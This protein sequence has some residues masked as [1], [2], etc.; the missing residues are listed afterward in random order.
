MSAQ[1]KRIKS[2]E[3][4]GFNMGLDDDD[5]DIL[6]GQG[7]TV[8][9]EQKDQKESGEVGVRVEESAESES[10]DSGEFDA[11]NSAASKTYQ[12]V[13]RRYRPK[14]FDELVGQSH[15]SQALANAILTNRVGHAYLFTGARGVGKT[16]TA[17]IFS[18]SLNCVLGPTSKP[19]G[20]CDSCVGISTGEDIDVLEIDGASNRGI[21]EIRQLRLN[22]SICPSRSRFK[23][24]II[25]EVH[26]LTRE[27]FNALLKILE[28]PPAH[29]KFIFCTTEPSKIPVTIL[30][31]CQRYDFAGIETL[32]IAKHLLEIAANEGVT[33]EDGVC[34]LLARRASG[35][36]RDAQ[37]LLEQLLSFA[38][39]RISLADVHEMLGTA[40][41]QVIFRLL[42]SISSC[43]TVNIFSELDAAISEGV[44]LTVLVEQMIGLFRDLLVIVSGGNA[45]LLIFCSAGQFERAVK[46]A[47]SFGVHRILAAMQIL[48]QT[49]GRMRYNTQTRVL[50][51]LALVR[52]AYLENFQMVSV[53]LDKLQ[54]GEIQVDL[55][56]KKN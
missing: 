3:T 37:S 52:I 56:E 33:A 32:Q 47:Q 30:S 12:V 24:Y 51:E 8:E 44:D 20:E 10:T 9:E 42:E 1:K 11:G 16:S 46:F 29:V 49:Y 35:S 25:D 27:A 13:A 43:D 5:D 15:I 21:D 39:Q 18:K 19:C 40:N 55:S 17:R 14:T 31:R 38:P 6:I 34:E 45:S 41:D 48:D 50:T 7:Q 53:L 28:E 4:V 22:A 36:M 2:V 54:R 23:V 26:M